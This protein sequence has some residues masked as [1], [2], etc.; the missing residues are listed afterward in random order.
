M[1]KL[2]DQALAEAGKLSEQEQDLLTADMMALLTEIRQHP[3]YQLSDEQLE[4]LR[5][6]MEEPSPQ[7]LSV[8]EFQARMQRLGT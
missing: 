1:T 2:L 3:K 4:E 8:E 6:R 7:L 5:R